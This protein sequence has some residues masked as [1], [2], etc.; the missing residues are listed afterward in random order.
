MKPR[1]AGWLAVAAAAVVYVVLPLRVS[2]YWLVVCNLA[3]I[4]AI[5]AVAL[6]LL[7]GYAGQLSLG[8]AAFLGAGAYAAS[9]VGGSGRG[10]LGLPLP[11][12]LAAAAVVGAAAGLVAGLF[13]VRV[14]GHTLAIVTLAL[15]FVAQ[16]VFRTWT[17]V[18]GGNAGRTDL[19][20]AASA[21]PGSGEQAWF[22]L[23]W[24]AVAAAVLLTA[25]AVRSR[26]G[27]AMVAVRDREGV[28]GVMGIDVDRTKLTAFVASSALAAVAGALYGSYKHYVG[29]EDWGLLLSIQYLAM[30]LIGGAGTVA[31]PVL[32]ALAVTALPRVVEQVSPLLPFVADGTGRGVTVAQ[33]DQL[34]F[35]AVIVA[36]VL[37]EPRGL[38]H[39]GTRVTRARAARVDPP[40]GEQRA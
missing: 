14:R 33:L 9:A 32:G 22:W 34:L 17:P 19:P 31:G 36:F 35:G 25:N 40:M 12:W 37:A 2:D 5:G 28:A 27:R 7:T 23:V 6:N 10:G 26:T 20:S 18:T 29:P 21:L 13:A 3:G 16:D 38:A 39:L 8:H 15:V 11:V 1:R 24:A 4:A 30:V